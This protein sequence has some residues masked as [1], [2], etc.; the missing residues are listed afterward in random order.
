M[1]PMTDQEHRMSMRITDYDI[2]R[3]RIVELVAE[4][5]PRPRIWLD[6]GCGCGGSIRLPIQRFPDTQFVLA[7]PSE[8]NIAM[9]KM[10][11]QGEQ[12]C[13]YVSRSTDRLNLG[14]GTLDVITSILS[15]HYYSDMDLKGKAFANCFRMLRK[16]GI[17]VNVEH[18]LQDCDQEGA[19]EEWIR[20][21][22]GRG[23]PKELADEM[24][25]R[26]YTEYF[27]LTEKEH[28][29][30]LKEAGFSEVKVFWK[31]CSDIG[32]YAIK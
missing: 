14:D 12:R 21:M 30:M 9:A 29:D 31:T 20:Y 5:D 24:I 10:T 32:L 11:M 3:E 2:L 18:C 13:L 4:H 7:D 1:L 22:T 23:L 8:E 25:Q 16:G 15:H 6:T 27:P 28:I 19:D 26:R 17:Y